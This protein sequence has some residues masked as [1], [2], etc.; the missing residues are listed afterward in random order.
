VHA[1]FGSFDKILLIFIVYYD[2]L[3]L[4]T[5]VLFTSGSVFLFLI[6]TATFPPFPRSHSPFQG[7]I[8]GLALF[9]FANH[10][11]LR[12]DKLQVGGVSLE[13]VWVKIGTK[14]GF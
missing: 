5:D 7:R 3:L 9:F 10:Q 2:R 13:R 14:S 12:S 6:S 4:F 8:L 11:G 1:E